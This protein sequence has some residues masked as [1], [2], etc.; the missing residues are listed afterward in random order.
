MTTSVPQFQ[1]LGNNEARTEKS[2]EGNVTGAAGRVLCRPQTHTGPEVPPRAWGLDLRTVP[3]LR[4]AGRAG[5]TCRQSQERARV[6]D[7]ADLVV[8]SCRGNSGGLPASPGVGTFKMATDVCDPACQPPPS[9]AQ[10]Q[11]RAWR[12]HRCWAHEGSRLGSNPGLAVP[13]Q[14]RL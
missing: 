12:K 14:P 3:H 1:G 2:C 11:P 6:M 9:S 8:G 7:A 10:T 4:E 5:Q 13:E